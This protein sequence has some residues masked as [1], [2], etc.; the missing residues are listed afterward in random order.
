M[1]WSDN[2]FDETIVSGQSFDEVDPFEEDLSKTHEIDVHVTGGR[3]IFSLHTSSPNVAMSSRLS[4]VNSRA[5]EP[6]SLDI[7]RVNSVCMY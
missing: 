2:R 6:N 7:L 1:N 3:R 4:P 5:D